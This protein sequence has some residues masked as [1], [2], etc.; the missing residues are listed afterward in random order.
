M[1]TCCSF[2]GPDSRTFTLMDDI[3]KPPWFEAVHSY[4]PV[5]LAIARGMKKMP[6]AKE[7]CNI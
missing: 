1:R 7:C 6:F 5:S 2:P 3:S 4:M